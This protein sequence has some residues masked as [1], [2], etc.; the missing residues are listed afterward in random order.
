[1][2]TRFGLANSEGEALLGKQT[3][4]TLALNETDFLRIKSRFKI[5]LHLSIGIY[6][7]GGARKISLGQTSAFLITPSLFSAP[8]SW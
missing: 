1:M 7:L 3:T 6:R 5:L 8:L 4:V 2:E